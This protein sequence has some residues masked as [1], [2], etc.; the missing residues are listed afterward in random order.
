MGKDLHTGMNHYGKGTNVKD[1][2]K[3][4]LADDHPLFRAG[5]KY[6][7]T[8]KT[9][10]VCTGEASDGYS[11]IDK[12][13]AVIPDIVLLDLD[14]P[15]LSGI[16]VIRILK[17]ILPDLKMLILSTYSDEKFVRD[18]ME[19]GADGYLL[20]NIPI[21]EME[22]II[23]KFHGSA[24]CFSPYLANLFLDEEETMNSDPVTDLTGRELEILQCIST[25]ATNKEI[26]LKL[27]I[28][29]ETVKSHVKNIYKKMGVKNRVEACSHPSVRS[30]LG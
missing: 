9:D 12:I 26:S 17:K 8:L 4:F 24:P 15:G 3:F 29:V 30:L 19:A 21:D 6:S 1:Q 13:Q 28:S 23:R 25:G 27:F 5:L 14:M 7:L 2:I 11:A 10:F 22:K 16:A 20:K 18:A